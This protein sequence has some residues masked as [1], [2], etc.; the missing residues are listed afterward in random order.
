MRLEVRANEAY[1]K[2]VEESTVFPVPV[3]SAAE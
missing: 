2:W 3:A 1:E